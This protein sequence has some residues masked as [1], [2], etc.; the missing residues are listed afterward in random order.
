MNN[1]KKSDILEKVMVFGEAYPGQLKKMRADKKLIKR[2]LFRR[3]ILLIKN[4]FLYLSGVEKFSDLTNFQKSL[5]AGI[6][7]LMLFLII[8]LFVI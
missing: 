4:Y 6:I 8:V 7:I 5:L 3:K 2:G 1:T